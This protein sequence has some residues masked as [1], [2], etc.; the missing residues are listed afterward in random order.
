MHILFLWLFAYVLP[1]FVTGGVLWI[2]SRRAGNA[3]RD[4]LIIHG[5]LLF[6][7]LTSQYALYLIG[8]EFPWRPHLLSFLL[9]IASILFAARMLGMFGIWYALSALLQ[10]LTILS[11][12]FLLLP[13]LSLPIV[14]LLVVPIFTL[15]HAQE[16]RHR[17]MRIILLSAWG[18]ASVTLFSFFPNIYLLAALHTFLGVIGIRQSIVYPNA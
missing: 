10:Q 1:A 7:V 8:L 17:Q 11:V 16:V 9:L 4:A 15:G 6:S 5:G 18:I 3:K 12:S 14:L 13:F 2:V